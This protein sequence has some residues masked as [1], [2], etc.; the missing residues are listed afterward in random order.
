VSGEIGDVTDGGKTRPGG[1]EHG[2]K[3]EGGGG[4][5]EARMGAR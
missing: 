4:S 1:R 2:E 3:G 5:L